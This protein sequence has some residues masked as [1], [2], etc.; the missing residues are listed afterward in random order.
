MKRTLGLTISLL[1]LTACNGG[2]NR[3]NIEWIQNMFDQVS[4]KSQDWDPKNPSE[5]QMRLPPPGT[6]ARGHLPYKFANDPI[7]AEKLVNP[8]AKDKTPKV[9]D[10]GRKTYDVYCAVCHGPTGAGDGTVAEKMAVKPRNLLSAES[11]A[12]SDGRIFHAI[13]AG[14]GVMGSYQSQ[15][16][17]ERTRWAVVNYVRS[18]Q[19]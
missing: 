3:P 16:P 14:R 6:V 19:R 2:P 8:L 17:N 9:I 12:F 10:L 15:I 7:A 5:N 11:K 4:I 1:F 18:L 13:T